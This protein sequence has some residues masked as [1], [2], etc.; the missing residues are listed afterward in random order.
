MHAT[1]PLFLSLCNA[2]QFIRA[3]AGDQF[4]GVGIIVHTREATLPIFSLRTNK[5]VVGSSPEALL[6]ELSTIGSEYHD[7]FHLVSESWEVT[8]ISQYFSP[9]I[10]EDLPVNRERRFGGRYLAA[11][12]GSVLPGVIYTGIASNGFGLAVF[13]A[14]REIY[15][16]G[17]DSVPV[18][19][20]S[21][22]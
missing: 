7:G 1:D 2:L 21:G 20:A 4:S 18:T 12:F 9:P 22:T 17:V 3:S 11:Q 6:S 19:S 13:Q 5:A 10:R 16:D 8:A 15:F 14:G